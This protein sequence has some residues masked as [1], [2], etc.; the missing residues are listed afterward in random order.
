M[1]EQSPNGIARQALLSYLAA[2]APDTFAVT[3]SRTWYDWQT[4]WAVLS[5]LPADAVMFNGMADGGDC[6]CRS[7]WRAQGSVVRPFPASWKALGKAAGHVRNV[8]MMEHMPRLVLAFVCD[9]GPSRGTRDAIT[10]AGHRGIPTFAFHQHADPDTLM[11][12]AI[13]GH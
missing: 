13:R 9:D 6:L 4:I 11:S 10:E 8:L 3:A 2:S 12:P 1:T 7:F 5:H